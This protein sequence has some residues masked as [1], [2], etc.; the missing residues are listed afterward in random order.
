[1][2]FG[3]FKSTEM[4]PIKPMQVLVWKI[5]MES[6]HSHVVSRPPVSSTT[7]RLR[8]VMLG[9]LGE[10]TAPPATVLCIPAMALETWVLVALFPD[11]G[12]V[13]RTQHIECKSDLKQTLQGK[14]KHKRLVSSGKSV[15]E[16]YR[17]FSDEIASEWPRVRELC[18]EEAARFEDD[19]LDV[20]SNTST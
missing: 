4:L 9:W 1:M 8:N 17:E 7:K 2:T 10:E 6:C 20:V 19:F 3:L 18:N 11:D 16:K 14:P 12:N 15:V 13:A 5:G